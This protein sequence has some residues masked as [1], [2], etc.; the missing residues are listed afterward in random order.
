MTV[1]TRK[2]AD[3][4]R[5]KIIKAAIT[6]FVKQGFSATSMQSI[7]D[8]A[9]VNQTLLYH[10]FTNKKTLWQLCKKQLLE[11]VS[12]PITLDA[13][14]GLKAVLRKIIEHRFELYRN[15]KIARMMMWQQLEP[16]QQGLI[17]GTNSSPS[18]WAPVFM[19]L[20]ALGL[21]RK[22]YSIEAISCWIGTSIAAIILANDVYFKNDKSKQRDYIDML[23]DSFNKLLGSKFTAD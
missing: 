4:T 5:D 11:Q 6:L 14:A 7:A 19:E 22:D 13:S 16:N 21:M 20:Q 17:G 8:K 9:A 3:V 23:L 1:K 10:H 18:K 12:V 15:K 2:F